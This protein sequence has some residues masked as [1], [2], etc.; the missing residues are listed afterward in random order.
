MDTVD[1]KVGFQIVKSESGYVVVFNGLSRPAT[2]EEII[3]WQ[4]LEA[5]TQ[6]RAV[7]LNN[8]V[9]VF[10]TVISNPSNGEAVEKLFTEHKSA[11]IFTTTSEIARIR[12]LNGELSSKLAGALDFIHRVAIATSGIEITELLDEDTNE[13]LKVISNDGLVILKKISEQC[14]ATPST[15]DFPL[16]QRLSDL[17]EKVSIAKRIAAHIVALAEADCQAILNEDC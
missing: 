5:Q 9:D 2:N 17:T 8:M 11:M 14:E 13:T 15:F 7:K 6:Q 12:K 10:E 1:L 16:H 4:S 3:L